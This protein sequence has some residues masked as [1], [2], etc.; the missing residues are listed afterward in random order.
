MTEARSFVLLDRATD[1]KTFAQELD[2]EVNK[3]DS[4]GITV[5]M[6]PARAPWGADWVAAARAKLHALTSK[7]SFVSV[8]F[9]AD[10]E[11]LWALTAVA[12]SREQWIEPWLSVLPWTR[13][14]VRKWLEE[15]QLT[16]DAAVDRLEPVTGYWGGLLETAARVTGGALD[17]AHNLDCMTKSMQDP[18]WRQHNRIRLTGGIEAAER[19]L[20]AMC[21]LG[22]GV[23]EGDLVEFGELPQ[24]LV[25]R[26]LRWAEP[27]GLV[28]RQPGSFW[29]LDAF[30]KRMLEDSA[31]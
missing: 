15:L 8:V 24:E 3:R 31:P 4:E 22:D 12:A 10:P 29:A 20:K 17:F 6:V 27:L 21:S 19:V 5:M 1:G 18:E 25:E 2:K 16:A 7:T 30:A 13:G 9:A 11:R 23:T 26:T 14:F 28:V